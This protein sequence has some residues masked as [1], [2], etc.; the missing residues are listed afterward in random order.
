MQDYYDKK[1]TISTRKDIVNK[2]IKDGLSHFKIALVLN[3]TECQ[4]K[5]LCTK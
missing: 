5:K 1:N 2:L 4:I 3:T